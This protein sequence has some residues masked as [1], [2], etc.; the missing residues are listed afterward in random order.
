MIKTLTIDDEENAREFLE[1]MLLKYFPQK[2][3]ICEKCHIFGLDCLFTFNG[4]RNFITT[5]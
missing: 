5:Q 1:K 2:F 4:F 3:F